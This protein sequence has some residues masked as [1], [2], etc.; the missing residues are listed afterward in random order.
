MKNKGLQIA[1]EKKLLRS[2]REEERGELCKEKYDQILE[3]ILE[4]YKLEH[5]SEKMK[6]PKKIEEEDVDIQKEM[7]EVV[8]ESGAK[9]KKS[10]PTEN[11]RT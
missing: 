10:L 8:K 11:K 7:K 3:R 1:K 2:D 6:S 5:G 4:N 9:R